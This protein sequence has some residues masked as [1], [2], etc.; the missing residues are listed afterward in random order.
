[1]GRSLPRS[2]VGESAEGKIIVSGVADAIAYDANGRIEIIVDWKSD[3]EIDHNRLK[4]Y[5][6]QLDAYR[7][8]TRCA[9]GAIGSHDERQGD[10]NIARWL[11]STS[12]T[13]QLNAWEVLDVLSTAE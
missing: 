13:S 5:R 6:G 12:L 9:K 2:Y 8:E 1:M 11:C 10:G 4:A 3:I 7:R